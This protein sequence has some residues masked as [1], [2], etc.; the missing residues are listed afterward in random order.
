LVRAVNLFRRVC[1]SFAF[2]GPNLDQKI[3]EEER[4]ILSPNLLPALAL[5]FFRMAGYL[6]PNFKPP[7]NGVC[8]QTEIRRRFFTEA[9]SKLRLHYI[10]IIT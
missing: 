9:L 8:H 6:L 2:T 10:A 3:R 5:I 1:G 4:S 7:Q